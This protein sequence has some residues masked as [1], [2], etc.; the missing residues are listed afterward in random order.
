MLKVL[1]FVGVTNAAVWL[2]GCVFFSLAAAPAI[3]QP[4][5]R[6]LFQDY[7]TGVVAQ[8]M[9][10]RYISFQLVCGAVALS[11]ALLEWLLDKRERRLLMPLLLAGL[12]GITLAGALWFLPS[13][14]GFRQAKYLAPTVQERQQAATSFRA[15]HSLSQG[16]NL[17]MLGGLTFYFWRT[18]TRPPPASPSQTEHRIQGLTRASLG[19]RET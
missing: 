3:F 1:R 2:G 7:Y 14:K 4:E 8:F 13:L 18:V 19:L 10:E 17:L 11:H 16:L 12:Y 5:M 6:R 9:Q 15:W